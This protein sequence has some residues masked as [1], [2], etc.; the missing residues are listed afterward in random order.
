MQARFAILQT[1]LSAGPSFCA[2]QL[3]PPVSDITQADDL[4]SLTIHLNRSQILTHGRPAV[5]K[6][7]QKLGIYKATADVEAATKMYE[8]LTRVDSWW[9]GKLRDE[10]LK[11]KAPRKVFVQAN[12][13][14]EGDGEV[15]LVE[16]EASCEGVIRSFAERE[17]I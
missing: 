10:V 8:E 17:Y 11:R 5:T 14:L 13:V 2:L 3:S 4:S 16:Y 12:T 6:L 15:R 1:F 7:L 9:G